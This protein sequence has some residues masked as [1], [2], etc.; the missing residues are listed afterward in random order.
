MVYTQD[1]TNKYLTDIDEYLYEDAS[2]L[3][4]HLIM[5]YNNKSNL[6][7]LKF[8]TSLNKNERKKFPLITSSNLLMHI[9]I[10]YFNFDSFKNDN[11]KYNNEINMIDAINMLSGVPLYPTENTSPHDTLRSVYRI[12]I[13][14]I[15]MLYAYNKKSTDINNTIK[16][17]LNI[18][19]ITTPIDNA[20]NKFIFIKS[21]SSDYDDGVIIRVSTQ[22]FKFTFYY[23]EP[24]INNNNN[25]NNTNID[26]N[27]DNN[28]NIMMAP[29]KCSLFKNKS[30]SAENFY[31]VE[32]MI[33]EN[34]DEKY[35]IIIFTY[36]CAYMLYYSIII[37]ISIIIIT[38]Q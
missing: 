10:L 14:S 26:N 28:T 33:K 21:F 18:N 23:D 22:L 8:S 35:Y 11:I 38:T 20:I 7:K 12:I 30:V 32:A 13:D 3:I 24:I 31:I 36:T 15:N 19:S 1:K 29:M 17:N 6:L 25:I 16:N 37:I 2:L 4:T 34:K 5:K 27:I 9:I